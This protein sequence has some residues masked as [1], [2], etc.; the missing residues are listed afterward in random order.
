MLPAVCRRA[1]AGLTAICVFLACTTARADDVLAGVFVRG[2]TDSTT[3]VS[4]KAE[5]TAGIVDD[6]TTVTAG[7]AADIW[8][9]ASIDI[10]TAA[11][12]PVSEQRDELTAGI[13]REMSDVTLRGG[14]RFSTENDYDSH[15]GVLAVIQRLAEGAATIE[16]GLSAAFDT[17]GRSGDE[18][19]SRGLS[20]VGFRLAYTQV[21]DPNTVLQGAYELMRRDGYQ[22]S[23]YRFVGLGGDG[24][25]RGTAQLCVAE[26]H[27]S[28]RWRNAWV[29]RLRRA[30]GD[31]WS[32]GLDYR[33]YIDDWGVA[34][35]TATAQAVW[36]PDEDTTVIARYRFYWQNEADFYQ[37]TY[38][39]ADARLRY[40]TRDRELS[41]M[42]THRLVLAYERTFDLTAAGPATTMT[43]AI[44]GSIL[45][46]RDF[47]GLDVVG[48][49]D[50]SLSL[51]VEL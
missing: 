47:V 40:V 18:R 33:F 3:V 45:D 50:A 12:Q 16:T 36:L 31:H 35:H 26:S 4:P 10:R 38:A 19:F 39:L 15:G 48:A 27:P 37:P 17:V 41:P 7:Y 46:Y 5:L 13:A 49:L 6:A 24:F 25:C 20:T 21:L 23:P 30:L 22:A 14:Y 51:T 28:I 43:L 8:T 32:T 9:S 29:A 1:K 11:T 44:G 34:S 42:S 2:D